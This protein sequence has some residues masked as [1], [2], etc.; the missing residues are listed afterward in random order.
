MSYHPSGTFHYF[1]IQY[2]DVFISNEA[3]DLLEGVS[4]FF[5][6]LFGDFLLS[7]E[8]RQGSLLKGFLKL[9]LTVT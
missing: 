6:P 1:E 5:I 2:P 4:T 3:K 7:E 9:D 8:L